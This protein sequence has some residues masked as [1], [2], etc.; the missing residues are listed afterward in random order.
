MDITENARRYHEKIFPHYQSEFVQTDP[1]FIER[2]DNFAFGEVLN[3]DD[4]DDKTRFIAFAAALIGCQAI[5]EY[6]V[7]LPAA[8]RDFSR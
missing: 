1:E 5:D 6:K 2:F 4:L 3:N 8:L 7:M